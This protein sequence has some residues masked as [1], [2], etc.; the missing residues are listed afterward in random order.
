MASVRQTSNGRK[1][2]TGEQIVEKGDL[3]FFYRPRVGAGEAEGIGDIQRFFMVLKPEDGHRFRLTVLGRKRLPEVGSH[4]RIWGF[5]D[6]VARSPSEIEAE[7]GE[8]HYETKTRGKRIV[9]AARPAGEGVYALVQFDRSLHLTYELELPEQPGEVQEELNIPHEGAYI[10]SI[11]NPEKPAPPGVGL[12]E[13]EEAQYSRPLQREFRGRRFATADP[14]LLDYEGAEFILIGARTD[15]ERAYG[16]DI[17]VE[18]E[19]A[20]KVGLFRQLKMS[21][22]PLEPLVE[23]EWR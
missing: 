22:R 16:L 8:Q 4:E 12:R 7:L 19:A 1:P 18:H 6:K 2:E 21:Q 9:A 20:R 11:K 23:G 3:A 10:L 17:D 14:R 13:D 15:P 5:I